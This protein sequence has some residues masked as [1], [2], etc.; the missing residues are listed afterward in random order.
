V[1]QTQ[2]QALQVA[3]ATP[4]F[5]L[6]L[7][8]SPKDACFLPEA[9]PTLAVTENRPFVEPKAIGNAVLRFL[10]LMDGKGSYSRGADVKV[11]WGVGAAWG[12]P[13]YVLPKRGPPC[14]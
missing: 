3:P 6:S 5:L 8:P 10:G 12:V 4:S 9:P 13:V 1:L 11:S 7:G 2:S 14:P